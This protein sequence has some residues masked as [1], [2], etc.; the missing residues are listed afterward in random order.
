MYRHKTF[1]RKTKIRVMESILQFAG[2]A[3]L[4]V[5]VVYNGQIRQYFD[6]KKHAGKRDI[7]LV[8]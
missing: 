6:K 7:D 1:F 5:A 3:V 8:N 4:V 2:I